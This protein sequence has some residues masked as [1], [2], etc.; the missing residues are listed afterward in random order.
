MVKS[1]LSAWLSPHRKNTFSQKRDRRPSDPIDLS[2]GSV[3]I[4]VISLKGTPGKATQRPLKLLSAWLTFHRRFLSRS[5]APNGAAHP[6][7]AAGGG[8]KPR[9]EA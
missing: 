3:R 7:P 1:S 5:Q 2:V 8:A 9:S 4:A 6:H